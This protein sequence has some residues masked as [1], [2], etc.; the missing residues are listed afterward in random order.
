VE[1]VEMVARSMESMRM[2]PELISR[3]PRMLLRREDFP[4][5]V[6]AEALGFGYVSV[7]TFPY[8]HR[9]RPSGLA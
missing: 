8:D 7:P 6:L 1:G 5:I 3:R 9:C 4:L 2:L